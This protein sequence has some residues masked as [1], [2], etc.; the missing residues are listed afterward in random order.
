MNIAHPI[1]SAVGDARG[2]LLEAVVRSDRSRTTREW[3]RRSDVSQP[4]AGELLRQFEKLGLV[5]CVVAGRSHMYT[6]IQESVLRRRLRTLLCLRDDIIESAIG[7]AV[8]APADVRVVL[9]GSLARNDPREAS[10]VDLCVV[11]PDSE[12]VDAWI[13]EYVSGLGRVSG[14]AVNVL[15]FEIVEWDNALDNR[16]RVALDIVRDGILLTG[17]SS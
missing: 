5:E 16:E 4:Q 1:I 6:A 11:A 8:D 17:E 10:D 9:F 15:R 13:E 3:A 14:L 7:R 2:R 12:E